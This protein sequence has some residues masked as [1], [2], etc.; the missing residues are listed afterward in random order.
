MLF[1]RKERYTETR[2]IMVRM[3][4]WTVMMRIMIV[5]FIIKMIMTMIIKIVMMIIGMMMM[6]IIIIIMLT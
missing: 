6:M 3:K 4:S 1:E 2:M 5:T